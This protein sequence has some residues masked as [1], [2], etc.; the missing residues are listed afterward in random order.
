[1]A[2]KVAVVSNNNAAI[3]NVYDKLQKPIS[4]IK[5]FIDVEEKNVNT[6]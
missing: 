6:L 1:M 5:Q 3:Q 2:K 4:R